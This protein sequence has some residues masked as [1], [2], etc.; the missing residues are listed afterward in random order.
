MGISAASI[1]GVRTPSL[2][3]KAVAEHTDHHLL[4]GPGAQEFA[5]S[6]GF[7]VEDDLNT[8]MRRFTQKNLDELPVTHSE[9]PDKIVGMIRRKEVI[10]KYNEVPDSI[11]E[12]IIKR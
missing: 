7:T 2:V 11:A 1:E 4:V 9:T 10:A 5:R 3:A 12:S 6:M 8:A